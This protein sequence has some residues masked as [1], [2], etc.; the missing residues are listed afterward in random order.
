M[1]RNSISVEV[2]TEFKAA[3]TECTTSQS[4]CSGAA[5]P[6]QLLRV[7]SGHPRSSGGDANKV[8]GHV[9]QL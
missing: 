1:V 7:Q 4:G 6:E 9:T 5:A 8:L 3:V 2:G